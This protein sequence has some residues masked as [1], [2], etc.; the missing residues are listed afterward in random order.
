MRKLHADVMF[1]WAVSVVLNSA[2]TSP[3]A[4]QNR[5]MPTPATSGKSDE[6]AIRNS[7]AMFAAA[8]DRH[9]A[10]AVAH[11]WTPDGEYVD[12]GGQRYVG[13]AA[14]QKEYADFFQA[15]PDAKLRVVVDSV[16]LVNGTT[17][18]EDG[19]AVLEPM[20]AASPG[21]GR[22]TAID[23]KQPDGRWLAASVRD[24]RVELPSTSGNLNDLQW[25]VGNW[26]AEHAGTRAE[27]TCHWNPSQDFL[28]R[29]YV[30]TQY[31]KPSASSTEIIAWDP[32]TRQIRSWTFSS[33]GGRAE[34]TWFPQDKG[35]AVVHQGV[36]PDGTPTASIDAWTQL[37]GDAI[38]WRSVERSAGGQPV[39]DAR[40]V[41]L[42]KAKKA[43]KEQ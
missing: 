39:K 33:D 11:M 5:S 2:M 25:L 38:G 17:A 35:W 37:L 20:P 26:V 12:E 42:K 16:R 14:I 32:S 13:R 3:L 40:D 19:H 10:Q 31:G 7:A 15:H 4:A 9:D 30:V 34:G 1:V 41:V 24:S 6:N 8:F 28:E 21:M 29:H 27:V 23:V 18:I 22:Y 43:N 36:L